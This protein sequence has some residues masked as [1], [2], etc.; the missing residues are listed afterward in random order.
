MELMLVVVIIGIVYA[1]A[2]S[3]FT[4]PDPKKLESFSLMTLPKYLRDNFALQDTK[5]VCFEP[6]KKC[7]VL[8]DGQWQEDPVELFTSSDVRSYSLDIEGFSKQ[9]E[10]AP[11]DIQDAYKKACFILHKRA[12]G[13]IDPIVLEAEGKFIYYKAGYEEVQS[14]KSLGNIQTQ[15]QNSLNMI[16]TEQ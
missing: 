14:F 8:V 12:N 3:S 4:P 7:N 2:L 13:A 9:S 16:R 1:L 10:F 6:C 11:H 5:L 15:Y